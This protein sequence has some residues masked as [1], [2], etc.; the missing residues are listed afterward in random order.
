MHTEKGESWGFFYSYPSLQTH[1]MTVFLQWD[2][3]QNGYLTEMKSGIRSDLAVSNPP[4]K[5]SGDRW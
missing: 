1:N 4:T 2:F 5:D 3:M